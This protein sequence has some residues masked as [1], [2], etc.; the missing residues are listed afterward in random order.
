MR[1]KCEVKNVKKVAKTDP[2]A[3]EAILEGEVFIDGQCVGHMEIHEDGMW[4][5]GYP[6]KDNGEEN[7]LTSDEEHELVEHMKQYLD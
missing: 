3:I 5:G 1:R 7:G 2:R 6:L 4:G